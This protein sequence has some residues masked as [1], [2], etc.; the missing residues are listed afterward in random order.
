MPRPIRHLPVI[1]RWD[2]HQCGNCC[3]DYW[4][5]VTPEE[6]RRIEEQGWSQLPEFQGIPL[7]VRYGPF[8]RRKWRLNQR[9]GDRCIFLDENGLCRI[10]TKFGPEAKPFAC[11]LYP[12][13]LVPVGNHYRVSLRFACPSA[14]ANKGRPLTEQMG[15]LKDYAVGFERWHREMNPHAHTPSEDQLLALGQGDWLPWSDMFILGDEFLRIL[16]S[17]QQSLV[18]RW[19]KILG[20]ARVCWEA[21]FDKVRGGRLREF[22]HLVG[23]S[24]EL[25]LPELIR[26][27]GRPTWVGR[28]LFRNFLAISLRK[29]Q[30]V[31]R[32]IASRSRLGL[33][34]AMWQ[35]LR[36]RGKLP[37]LQKGLPEVT[38]AELEG[39]LP[40]F[41]PS[42]WELLDRYYLVKMQSLQ[43]FG[44][45]FMNYPFLIGLEL[46]ALTLP[47]IL[48]LARGYRERGGTAAVEK[49]VQV[50]DENFGYSP[51][52]NSFR[53]RLA[54]RI[55]ASRRET[56]KLLLWYAR[57]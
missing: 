54:L 33:L 39:P 37:P 52:L 9:E 5:P 50:I 34:L 35:M 7:F 47:M 18:V 46:L 2:C 48:W 23:D 10:H 16:E 36:G 28:V 57:S 1:Q 55:L 29:D 4:V 41:P 51:F 13:V 20:I 40:E 49:A 44:P 12:Y 6:R 31:R 24:V 14:T 21:R 43:F 45:A 27:S 56:E 19:L 32:G 11:R 15:E 53:Q 38:F 30:G 25:E 3:T 17:R 42:A 22:L 8:W 26:R